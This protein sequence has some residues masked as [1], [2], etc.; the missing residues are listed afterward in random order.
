MYEEIPNTDFQVVIKRLLIKTF[1]SSFI[2]VMLMQK[3]VYFN[4]SY[5]SF[6]SKLRSLF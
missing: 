6:V 2:S 4:Y 1:Q 5:Y 3:M